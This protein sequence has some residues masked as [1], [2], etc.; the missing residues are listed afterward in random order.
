MHSLNYKFIQECNC[1]FFKKITHVGMM[2]K[3][4]NLLYTLKWKT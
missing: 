1:P 3:R 2:F 4:I